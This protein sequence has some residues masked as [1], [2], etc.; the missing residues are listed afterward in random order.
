MKKSFVLLLALPLL[1]VGCNSNDNDG[2]DNQTFV[3][4]G[5]I[6]V[7]KT[8]LHQH[9][10]IDLNLTSSEEVTWSVN[11]DAL[12]SITSSGELTT[13]D[14]DGTLL[15][16]ATSTRNDDYSVSKLFTIHTISAEEL[17]EKLYSI[18]E[19][20]NYTLDWKGE[21]LNSTTLETMSREEVSSATSGDSNALSLYGD[22]VEKGNQLKITKDAFYWKYGID[23]YGNE[24]EGGCYNSPDGYFYN[25]DIINGA[26]V[27]GDVDYYSAALN[28][29]D[30]KMMYS[31]D[32]SYFVKDE[33]K[34]EDSNLTLNET[35]DALLYDSTKDENDHDSDSL[36]DVDYSIFQALF[37]SVD[38]FYCEQ[39][40]DL[41]L[42][43]DV[44][45][46]I[47]YDDSSLHFEFIT[48]D[49]YISDTYS[50]RYKAIFDVK[51]IGTTVIPGLEEQIAIDQA[52]LEG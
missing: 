42:T 34:V 36:Y 17:G 33:F 19:N 13:K 3:D 49:L 39:F 1:L 40:I 24:Y 48:Q 45:G 10:T 29:P 43:N 18:G 47:V 44:T 15:V 50:V 2:K 5:E 11:D 30:Y 25:Y 21:F 27:K 14:K 20:Y 46:T 32:L 26:F 35:Y 4:L 52:A 7:E 51:E 37:F 6:E 16:T 12:A 23:G 41:G 22:L 9:E 31:S 8:D 28:W 38:T